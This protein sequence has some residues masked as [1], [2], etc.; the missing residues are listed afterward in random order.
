MRVSFP[1]SAACLLVVE[2]KKIHQLGKSACSFQSHVDL[3]QDPPHLRR[4][5]TH[6]VCGE[7]R[8]RTAAKVELWI[9]GGAWLQDC[10]AELLEFNTEIGVF[11]RDYHK[12]MF[13]FLFIKQ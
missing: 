6:R 9:G 10:K 4:R 1:T 8:A 2:A 7:T 5:S 13:N 11:R 3:L 12:H